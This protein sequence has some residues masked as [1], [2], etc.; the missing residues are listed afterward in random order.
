LI[1][2][3]TLDPAKDANKGKIKIWEMNELAY[4]KL[5]LLMMDT[6]ESAGK[7]AFNIVKRSKSTDYQDG[8][9]RWHGKVPSKSIC[10]LQRHPWF[11]SS[12]MLSLRRKWT[13]HIYQV[14][15]RH[16]FTNGQDGI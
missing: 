13:R 6:R 3:L 2:L 4:S 8:M 7:V 10:Q 5:I 16:K 15:W 1:F 9:T 11:F 14:P 12:T